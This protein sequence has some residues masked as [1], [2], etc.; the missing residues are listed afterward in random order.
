MFARLMNEWIERCKQKRKVFEREM[1]RKLGIK[2]C[3]MNYKQWRQ[4]VQL[5]YIDQC[6]TP[7]L[8]ILK[9]WNLALN[10]GLQG[11]NYLKVGKFNRSPNY[12]YYTVQVTTHTGGNNVGVFLRI[13]DTCAVVVLSLCTFPGMFVQF[14]NIC[15]LFYI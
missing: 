8:T 11:M 12:Y 1:L 14:H 4:W 7:L 15:N 2:H 10:W 5:G 13:F 3:Q 6:Y 9:A